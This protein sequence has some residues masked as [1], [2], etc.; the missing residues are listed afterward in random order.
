M[1]SFN[2]F[3]PDAGALTRRAFAGVAHVPCAVD[4]DWRAVSEGGRPGQG[5]APSE[6]RAQSTELGDAILAHRF[7][8]RVSLTAH[9]Q[10]PVSCLARRRSWT[11]RWPGVPYAQVGFELL[12]GIS[13]E[14]PVAEI[15]LQHHE[16]LDGSGYP[17][18]LRGAE[19]LLEARVLGVADVVEA[20]SSHRP[21]RPAFALDYALADVVQGSGI[22]YDP[23][24]VSACVALFGEGRF[25][26][27]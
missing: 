19:I 14:W 21:Y 3:R 6:R 23:E 5:Q 22:A 10:A 25:A 15:V 24:V 7:F 17:Q 20:L 27:E 13:F 16:R 4:S 8:T 11:L 12:K 1:V 18:G 2:R 9:G 26:F